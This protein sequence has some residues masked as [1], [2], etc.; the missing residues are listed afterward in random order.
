[1]DA[2]LQAA[3]G[4]ERLSL[5]VQMG[6]DEHVEHFSTWEVVQERERD[7]CGCV[8]GGS[9]VG[10]LNHLLCA[11]GGVAAE[12]ATAEQHLLHANDSR[13]GETVGEDPS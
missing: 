5:H 1:M 12:C 8:V 13:E 11:A 7:A 2:H 3:V 6:P 10:H 9:R 4:K